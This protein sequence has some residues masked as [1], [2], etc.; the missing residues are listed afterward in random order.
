MREVVDEAG[1][2]VISPDC[3]VSPFARY[4]EDDPDMYTSIKCVSLV[5]R[6]F[7]TDKDKESEIAIYAIWSHISYSDE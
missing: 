6:W 3:D 7:S 5:K 4:V 2:V 1:L